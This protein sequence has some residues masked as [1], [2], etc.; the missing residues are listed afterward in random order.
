MGTRVKGLEWLFA[1]Q[2]EHFWQRSFHRFLL[3]S[4]RFKKLQSVA[5]QFGLE[6]IARGTIKAMLFLLSAMETLLGHLIRLPRGSRFSRF[7]ES[8]VT[9][10]H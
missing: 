6:L 9:I 5:D 2:R 4:S 3:H 1:M 8:P 7:G 10:G